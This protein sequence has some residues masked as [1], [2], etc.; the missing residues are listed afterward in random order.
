MNW[1]KEALIKQLKFKK[2]LDLTKSGAFGKETKEY[3]NILHPNDAKNGANFYCYNNP[4][5]W[6]A[7]KEWANKDKGKKV[8]FTSLGLT[9]MLRSEHIPF[10]LFYPLEK[11]RNKDPNLLNRFLERLLDNNINIDKVTRIKIEFASNPDLHKSKL[12]DDN[13]SFDTY[14]EYFDGDK[15][16][17]L[18]IEIKYTEKSYPYGKTEKDRMFNKPDSEYNRL[19]KDCDFYKLEKLGILKEKKLKQLWRNHLLGIKLV[20][21]KELD[22]FYSVH[23][24]PDGNTYQKE[25][26]DMYSDCLANDKKQSFVPVT[27]EKFI[28][29]ALDILKY[30]ENK[31]WIDYL[32]KRY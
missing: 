19:T 2:S 3:P 15:K 26:C 14:I 32:R 9:N 20:E 13:T 12:L 4:E 25:A 23:L 18:G 6:Q 8:D 5:E 29:V 31:E 16:C 27:F 21:L 7:L 30:K 24:Y 17:G 22:E 11:L 10:N 1:K 28:S